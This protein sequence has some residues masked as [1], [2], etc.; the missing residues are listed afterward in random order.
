MYR[1]LHIKLYAAVTQTESA[2]CIFLDI[3]CY[4]GNRLTGSSVWIP[5]WSQTN[6]HFFSLSY[7]LKSFSLSGGR[8]MELWKTEKRRKREIKMWVKWFYMCDITLEKWKQ[9][10]ISITIDKKCHLLF[11]SA[12][13][14]K[15]IKPQNAL[16]WWCSCSSSAGSK[17][18]SFYM[19]YWWLSV[20][21]IPGTRGDICS[22]WNIFFSLNIYSIIIICLCTSIWFAE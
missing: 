2:L 7:W 12:T 15:S 20:D 8:F 1:D 19:C 14:L 21:T 13:V 3:T 5:T 9:N 18:H 17:Y 22:Q 6:S 4:H 16:S 10:M 11:L